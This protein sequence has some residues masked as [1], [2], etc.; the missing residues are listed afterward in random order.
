MPPGPRPVPAASP[1]SNS[2]L[3]ATQQF[4]NFSNYEGKT[5][6]KPDV[7][8]SSDNARFL[9]PKPINNNA[10]VG[11]TYPLQRGYMRMITEGY[12]DQALGSKL[13]HKRFH[14]QFNPDV[15][16][17]S[18]TARNDVQFWMNQ[19]PG[20][21]VSPI[22]GD[23]NFAFEFILNREQEM[24][25]GRLQGGRS[26]DVP[27]AIVTL[28]APLPKGRGGPPPGITT[29]PAALPV[30][31]ST[32]PLD[33]RTPNMIGVLADLLVFD[34]IIG[35]GINADLFDTLTKQYLANFTAAEKAAN[36]A[37]N[38]KS[39]DD[40][41][42]VAPPVQNDAALDKTLRL[43]LGNSA[44][45]ISQPVRILFSSLFMVEGF[46][47]ATTV[48]FNKFNQ[49][50]VPT[51]CTVSVNMQA[52]YIGF[53]E[54]DTFLTTTLRDASLAA[55]NE[56]VVDDPDQ[57]LMQGITPFIDFGGMKLGPLKNDEVGPDR[58][59][60]SST[61]KDFANLQWATTRTKECESAMDDGH[62]SGFTAHLTMYIYYHSHPYGDDPDNYYATHKDEVVYVVTDSAPWKEFD[63]GSR[64]N[65]TRTREKLGLADWGFSWDITR[66]TPQ[67]SKAWDDRDD[68]RYRVQIAISIDIESS[69]TA[70]TS[71]QWWV[72]DEVRP[73]NSDYNTASFKAI[74]GKPSWHTS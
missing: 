29:A 56:A 37:N 54:K 44:F 4:Y 50:M 9:W 26:V 19:D 20:Q 17:R 36:D 49:A 59:I 64:W 66:A 74:I 60:P 10:I 41:D 18:V 51:Q 62:I 70:V 38:G 34:S 57:I 1:R 45:L 42:F 35:Q 30:F 16:V 46:I 2:N 25:T 53:A 48:T 7:Y 63:T 40:E 12:G 21:L 47:S 32:V 11:S 3:L 6:R 71:D 73:Y 68:A 33:S 13:K 39:P 27:E 5:D 15:L 28:P 14:F 8:G 69:F 67:I 24:A 61:S 55:A 22:P 58:F 43:S 72:M 23:A 52:M 65:P 31:D